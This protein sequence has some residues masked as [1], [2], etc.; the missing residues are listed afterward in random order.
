MPWRRIQLLWIRQAGVQGRIYEQLYSSRSV[1]LPLEQKIQYAQA[2]AEEVK[3]IA[4]DTVA[5]KEELEQSH[6]T[7]EINIGG[8]NG[9]EILFLS[10]QVSYYSTL[11]LIY[12]AISTLEGAPTALNLECI[13]LARKAFRFH[14]QFMDLAKGS[15]EVQAAYLQWL[16]N[17]LQNYPST[18]NAY[19]DL[20]RT[21]LFAPFLPF[22]AIFCHIIDTLNADDLQLLRDFA[23]SLGPTSAF[24]EAI[25]QLHRLS[26]GLCKVAALYVEVKSRELEDKILLPDESDFDLYLS[27]FGLMPRGAQHVG[28]DSAQLDPAGQSRRL[29]DR[30]L[31]DWNVVGLLEDDLYRLR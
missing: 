10:E 5:M 29:G 15:K 26:H 7:Y 31:S 28:D 22:I 30:F 25:E 4:Q 12:R 14:L 3:A 20:D 2:V 11:T 19:N 16:V 23:A 24:S 6:D 17:S 18:V 21:I 27:Q 13:D 9:L 1:S 8:L